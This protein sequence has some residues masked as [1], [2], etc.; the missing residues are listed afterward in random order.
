V[1]KNVAACDTSI[2]HILFY[3]QQVSDKFRFL[4]SGVGGTGIMTGETGNHLL[5]KQLQLAL[6]PETS[7]SSLCSSSY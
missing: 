4:K 3:L 2:V 5:L 1:R 6:R 7:G